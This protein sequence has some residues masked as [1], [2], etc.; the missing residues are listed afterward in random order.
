VISN[1]D[2]ELNSEL[3]DLLVS[4]LLGSGIL[5]DLEFV[6]PDLVGVADSDKNVLSLDHEFLHVVSSSHGS[7]G[8]DDGVL[9]KLDE[10]E[11]SSDS[12][13]SLLVSD[14]SV[15]DGK[16]V[17]SD[18][19]E[20]GEVGL[21]ESGLGELVLF[22][23]SL[24][25][26]DHAEFVSDGYLHLTVSESHGTSGD[27]RNSSVVDHEFVGLSG[28]LVSSSGFSKGND[29]ESESVLPFSV[30]D[31]LASLGSESKLGGV[32]DLDDPGAD[33]SSIV[34][35]GSSGVSLGVSLG[36][37]GKFGSTGG[38]SQLGERCLEDELGLESE[39][40]HSVGSSL[41]TD[42]L[43]VVVVGN[44][45][46]MLSELGLTL[47]VSLGG[48]LDL[49]SESHDSGSS[50]ESLDRGGSLG[51]SSVLGAEGTSS[52]ELGVSSGTDS[53]LLLGVGVSSGLDGEEVS[54]VSSFVI[55]DGTLLSEEGD[56]LSSVGADLSLL[57]H[58]HD[59]VGS[60]HGGDG[61]SSSPSHELGSL[62]SGEHLLDVVSEESDSSLHVHP[63]LF[64][65]LLHASSSGDLDRKVS[66][67]SDHESQVVH[68]LGDHSYEVLLG[69][70]ERDVS[71]TEDDVDSL[72]DLEGLASSGSHAGHTVLGVDP[73]ESPLGH[74]GFESLHGFLGLGPF[75]VDLL[76]PF[77]FVVHEFLGMELLGLVGDLDPESFRLFV[78]A[79]GTVVLTE[80]DAEHVLGGLVVS[81][82][83]LLED[84]HLVSG[85]A[86][87]DHGGVH[88]VVG[89]FGLVS[90]VNVV[91]PV[92]GGRGDS[93][94]PL[95]DEGLS[96]VP[97]TDGNGLGLDGDSVLVVVSNHI[98]VGS[99]LLLDGEVSGLSGGVSLG[100]P[101]SSEL[102]SGGLLD[103]LS[104]SDNSLVVP[105]LVSGDGSLD[106]GDSGNL[107]S[108]EVHLGVGGEPG[109]VDHDLVSSLLSLDLDTEHLS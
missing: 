20:L 93:D 44:A 4:S 32:D 91:H 33:D 75:D 54:G 17:G 60:S 21:V 36:D 48:N 63:V 87:L 107:S 30:G 25:V 12:P 56:V 57:P 42:G 39:L 64:S 85:N 9:G 22:P 26:G 58:H 24:V 77:V 79:D 99:V 73:S 34:G 96:G 82:S 102:L 29:L 88:E 67:S 16:V 76:H 51:F 49:E 61:L 69:V 92:L 94:G 7:V 90:H 95:L 35:H 50:S 5:G 84:V 28:S 72:E 41:T 13:G 53:G 45:L 74:V 70:S 98:S 27:S 65:D 108:D 1:S 89:V 2:L 10:V 62:S 81:V 11:L 37:E 40:V 15:V 31:S 80:G 105:D 66:S 14:L 6:H 59:D 46:G 78:S 68:L 8:H 106:S 83:L 109:L 23:H 18:G 47:E 19:S 100:F 104:D 71:L 101:V 86:S 43:S 38:D 97:F 52:K 55:S 3:D 103:L